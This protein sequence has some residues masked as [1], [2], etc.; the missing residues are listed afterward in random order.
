MIEN[1]SRNYRRIEAEYSKLLAKYEGLHQE[2][3]MEVD[4]QDET[5]EEEY[6]DNVSALKTENQLLRELNAELKHTNL[7]LNEM[8]TKEKERPSTYKETYAGIIS[9]KIHT[10][11]PKKIPIIVVRRKEKDDKSVIKEKVFYYL[12]KEKTI[13]TKKI[14]T[15]SSDV[16]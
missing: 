2:N 12:L 16:I 15:K 8:L 11:Q 10:P 6:K 4:D 3:R 5:Y 13:Q 1:I 7:L 9:K 14:D